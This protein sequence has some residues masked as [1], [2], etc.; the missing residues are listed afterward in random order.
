[1]PSQRKELHYFDWYF[2]RGDRWYSG[3][4][5]DEHADRRHL[6]VGEVTPD[7]LAH[8]RAPDRIHATLP[9]AA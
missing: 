9:A 7:Y 6:A 2:E 5:P 3:Y 1:M 8:P 4:F